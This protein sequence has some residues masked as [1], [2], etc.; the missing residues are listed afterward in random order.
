MKSSCVAH[1]ANEE[2]II[3]HG[4][5]MDATKG[6][7]CA[8]AILSLLESVSNY[9][10]AESSTVTSIWQD[11]MNIWSEQRIH[12]SLHTLQSLGFV[13]VDGFGVNGH[14][15]IWINED[16]VNRWLRN[17]YRSNRVT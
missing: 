12:K 8:C 15:A 5:Q 7:P 10:H 1:P 14:M 17:H 13:R 6:D 9:N 4:W 3:I 16:A 2:V 11:L